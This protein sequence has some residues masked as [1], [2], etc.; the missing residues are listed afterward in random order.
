MATSSVSLCPAGTSRYSSFA[1]LLTNAGFFYP[2]H[3][4]A[5]TSGLVAKFR[6]YGT[7]LTQKHAFF[8]NGASYTVS[9][10]GG[11]PTTYTGDATTNTSGVTN[12]WATGLSNGWHTV[13]IR[14]LDN[15]SPNGTTVQYTYWNNDSGNAEGG[16]GGLTATYTG[17]LPGGYSVAFDYVSGW[18]PTS[19]LAQLSTDLGVSAD[20]L[21]G[22]ATW[23]EYMKGVAFNGTGSS[24]TV[25]VQ[26]TSGDVVL[27]SSTANGSVSSTAPCPYTA[28]EIGATSTVDSDG[29]LTLTF[30]T[31]NNTQ[32]RLAIGVQTVSSIN[33][34][35]DSRP[36]GTFAYAN[37]THGVTFWG[38]S[39]LAG[40]YVGVAENIAKS[41]A[42]YYW[43]KSGAKVRGMAI[44]GSLASALTD[45]GAWASG[46]GAFNGLRLPIAAA[47]DT[48]FIAFRG[49][50][51][52]TLNG[53]Y[54]FSQA[55]DVS[56]TTT[57]RTMSATTVANDTASAIDYIAGVNSSLKML[58]A[59]KYWSVTSNTDYN[60]TLSPL[61]TAIAA[62]VTAG[63][64]V[65]AVDCSGWDVG[66][67]AVT[68]DSGI[69]PTPDE[70]GAGNDAEHWWL[71]VD[72]IIN[73][74]IVVSVSVD[75][76]SPKIVYGEAQTTLTATV[77]VSAG[78]SSGVTWS[79]ISGSHSVNSGTGV[80]TA[81]G[82]GQSNK[83]SVIRATSIDD[84][85]KYA[86]ITV[87]TP[88]Q[89]SSGGGSGSSNKTSI[90]I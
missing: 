67:N 41:T 25:R 15:N 42:V 74:V 19:T 53:N 88:P 79:V 57:S 73:S 50:I 22:N 65:T 10:D 13:E 80:V 21:Q 78:T 14:A 5:T 49:W 24:M 45:T 51:N 16:D 68:L 62:R 61:S 17:S 2:G 59:K 63:R 83:D 71:V 30:A 47:A 86:Q 35:A 33:W 6:F 76:S 4:L 37:T 90:G 69:H 38:D 28:T 31:T 72:G 81:P 36:A 46:L 43:C 7:G 27:F 54:G 55:W 56:N 26:A 1:T 89:T 75:Q 23:L 18:G 84:A 20:V 87:R 12:T 85:S 34:S 52:D 8:G 66:T 64:L 9:I 77:T 40:G 39:T 82:A 60:N 3:L 32:Y 29:F 11:A 44:S 70:A 48:A 58:F